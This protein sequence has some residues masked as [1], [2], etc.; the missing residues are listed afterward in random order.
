MES[1]AMP[2]QVNALTG[3]ILYIKKNISIKMYTVRFIAFIG[4]LHPIPDQEPEPYDIY[5]QKMNAVPQTLN[6]G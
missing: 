1:F 4:V 3:K 5:M 2:F 6:S